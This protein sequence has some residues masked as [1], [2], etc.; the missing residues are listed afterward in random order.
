MHVQD[1][2]SKAPAKKKGMKD[3]AKDKMAEHEA[4]KELK[5]RTIVMEA[6][7]TI[8]A[9]GDTEGASLQTDIPMDVK[10]HPLEG[11]ENRNRATMNYSNMLLAL[12]CVSHAL[13]SILASLSPL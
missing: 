10:F 11:C 4:K 5:W 8:V 6:P 7:G 3:K 1:D 2:K 13:V 9:A 12:V